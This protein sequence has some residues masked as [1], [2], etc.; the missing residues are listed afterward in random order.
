MTLTEL[1]HVGVA[2]GVSSTGVAS[3]LGAGAYAL[4]KR[5]DAHLAR[6]NADRVTAETRAA[7]E[8]RVDGMLQSFRAD[9]D[10][11]NRR[12]DE[13]LDRHEADRADRERIERESREREAACEER[14]REALTKVAELSSRMDR[15][16]PQP[17]PAVG[18]K[19]RKQ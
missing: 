18:A 9:L 6:A 2:F 14:A 13:C 7:A 4:R 12:L 11:A 5:S 19:E 3:L 17:R 8:Q 16:T 1:V 15:L 10:T